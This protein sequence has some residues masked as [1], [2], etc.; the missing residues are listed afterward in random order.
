VIGTLSETD[1]PQDFLRAW[2]DHL[3]LA[4]ATEERVSALLGALNDFMLVYVPVPAESRRPSAPSERPFPLL[5]RRDL[6]LTPVLSLE[7]E[8]GRVRVLARNEGH[9]QVVDL[10]LRV[11]RRNGD[12]YY[13]RP[14]G[15]WTNTG[16]LDARTALLVFPTGTRSIQLIE[17]KV[18]DE[19]Q[20]ARLTAWLHN[21]G[22]APDA[23]LAQVGKAVRG[24]L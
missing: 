1:A 20:G 2:L 11:S 21:P 4:G 24:Q 10:C 8:D 3:D 9:Q 13:L 22:M 18:P 6:D 7:I 12:E 23:P 14:T 15:S 16:P 19:L 5:Q 17:A